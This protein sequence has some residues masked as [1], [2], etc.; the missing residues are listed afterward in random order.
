MLYTASSPNSKLQRE[1]WLEVRTQFFHTGFCLTGLSAAMHFDLN[2]ARC[3]VNCQ[4][5]SHKVGCLYYSKNYHLEATPPAQGLLNT[6]GTA[7][8]QLAG[9]LVKQSRSIY[10]SMQ[11]HCEGLG[12]AP[13][14][15]ICNIKQKPYNFT[16]NT[17]KPYLSA[18]ASFLS[19]CVISKTHRSGQRPR[20]R[21]LNTKVRGNENAIFVILSST[22]ISREWRTHRGCSTKVIHTSS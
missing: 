1:P 9:C 16:T 12:M 14:C 19:G 18:Q 20:G 2:L 11:R 4:H 21:Q 10:N 5:L 8:E 7:V 15:Y 13:T 6:L 17:L 22:K 3:P